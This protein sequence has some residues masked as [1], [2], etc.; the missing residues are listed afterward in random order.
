ML[1]SPWS[2]IKIQGIIASH[3]VLLSL[4]NNGHILATQY[5]DHIH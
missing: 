4:N 5:R 1:K 2:A 3:I